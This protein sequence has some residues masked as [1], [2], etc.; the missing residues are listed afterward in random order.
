MLQSVN[1]ALKPQF[2]ILPEALGP[3]TLGSREL[4]VFLVSLLK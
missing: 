4:F 1:V 3:V 2:M